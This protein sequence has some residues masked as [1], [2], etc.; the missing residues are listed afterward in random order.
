MDGLRRSEEGSWSPNLA[1]ATQYKDQTGGEAKELPAPSFC[2][3]LRTTAR[4][5]TGH[6][7]AASLPRRQ[8]HP[9]GTGQ[10]SRGGPSIP[11]SCRAATMASN[12]AAY[13]VSKVD[14][15]VNW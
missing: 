13:V 10:P 5:F 7:R 9:A 2:A 6:L 15:L 14:Q 11:Q 3:L 8:Q 12:K 1:R 4:F